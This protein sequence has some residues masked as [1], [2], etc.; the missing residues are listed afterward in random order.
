MEICS[1][2]QQQHELVQL[3]KYLSE[4]LGMLIDRQSSKL[5]KSCKLHMQ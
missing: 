1:Q 3:Q 5:E 2:D 4:L